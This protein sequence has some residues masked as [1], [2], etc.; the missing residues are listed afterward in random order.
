MNSV[1]SANCALLPE[2]LSQ[3]AGAAS[4]VL[5]ARVPRDLLYLRGHFDGTPVV[6]GVVQLAWVQHYARSQ[7]QLPGGIHR[8]EQLKFQRLLRPPESFTL[9]IELQRE[10]SLV[11]F[12]LYHD[13]R[14]FSSG[15]ILFGPQAK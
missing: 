2:I 1:A 3:E 15:R 7:F 8:L 13:E 5:Q 12:R 9:S 11:A 14:I 4:L 6:A 10:R